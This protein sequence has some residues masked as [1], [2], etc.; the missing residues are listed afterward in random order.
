MEGGGT[1]PSPISN[2]VSI[3]IFLL[4]G[5]LLTSI[6]VHGAQPIRILFSV[7][8]FHVS[9]KS[10]GEEKHRETL[11]LFSFFPSRV[12]CHVLFHTGFC[13][14]TRYQERERESLS[15]ESSPPFFLVNFLL[16]FVYR[17]L[18]FYFQFHDQFLGTPNGLKSGAYNIFFH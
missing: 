17:F 10:K 8:I 11:L 16:V 1:S 6:K 4:A 3:S 14:A 12:Y 2:D 9:G 7:S 5:R 13:S 15:S 18:Q